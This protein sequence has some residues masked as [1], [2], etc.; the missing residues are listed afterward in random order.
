[1][2]FPLQMW[3]MCYLNINISINTSNR[4]GKHPIL[5]IRLA[6]LPVMV[7]THVADTDTPL[8]QQSVYTHHV[9]LQRQ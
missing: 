6:S 1:M 7:K 8:K 2:A 5:C 9:A 3:S 4:Y